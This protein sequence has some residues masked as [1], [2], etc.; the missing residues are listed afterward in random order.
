MGEIPNTT[1]APVREP[2]PAHDEP[3]F[4][5]S[6]EQFIERGGPWEVLPRNL[7]RWVATARQ[8]LENPSNPEGARVRVRDVWLEGKYRPAWMGEPA[9]KRGE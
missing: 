1:P 8:Y 4:M 9:R 6:K 5:L 2:E 3:I 7:G